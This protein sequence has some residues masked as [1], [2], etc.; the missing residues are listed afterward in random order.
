MKAIANGALA[1][2]LL[3]WAMPLCGAARWK[4]PKELPFGELATLELHEEDPGQP[5]IPRPAEEKL[6]AISIRSVEPTLDGRGWRFTVQAFQ[7]G[8]ARIPAMDLGDGRVTPELRLLVVRT[9]PYGSPWMGVGGGHEDIL[10][11][12]PFPVAWASLLLLPLLP[13]GWW[14]LRVWM[15]NSAKRRMHHARRS[16]SRHWP[17]G[18]GQR[19]A[20][21]AAHLAGRELLVACFGDEARSWGF[22]ELK[23]RQ[24][25]PWAD[26]VKSLDTARFSGQA[27]TFPHL[28]ELLDA[29]MPGSRR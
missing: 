20:L 21:D 11:Y 17:P 19:E 18:G 28:K 23:R 3:I 6:G 8:L 16:F 24:L 27:P 4:A 25:T 29:L 13:L 2:A 7:P 1:C 9:V 5:P 26:W 22:A 12:L 14:G 10:P 15:K